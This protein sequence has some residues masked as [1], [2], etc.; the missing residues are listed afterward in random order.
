MKS[1]TITAPIDSTYI[2]KLF[3]LE[4]KIIKHI[5][6][7]HQFDG[8]HVSVELETVASQ[9][10]VC[11]HET[12]KVNNYVK[13]KITHSVLNSIPCYI[14]Y[15]AR[16]FKCPKCG[17]TFY[18]NNPFTIQ[19]M[20]ISL[21]TVYN[22]LRD[23]KSFNETF[24]SVATRYN[25][26]PT[27]VASIFDNHV[28]VPR[29]MLPEILSIDEVYAFRS[30]PLESNYVCVLL[31]FN[32]NKV[33]DI[34]PTRRYEDLKKYFAL[35]PETERKNVRVVSSDLW[36]S[37]R[38]ITK[39]CFPNAVLAAD[40]F[41]IIQDFSRCLTRV[42]IDIM[43]GFKPAPNINKSELKGKE[44]AKYIENDT[45]YYLL[46]KFHWLLNKKDPSC[47]DPNAEK[48]YNKKLGKFY[49]YYDLR[50]LVVE[51]DKQIEEV[52]YLKDELDRFYDNTTYINAAQELN[53]LIMEFSNSSIE[54][55]NKF[56][57]TLQEWKKEIINSFIRAD[58]NRHISNGPIENVNKTIK[59]IK[60]NANGYT[61]WERFR[62]RVLFV[63][64]S[65]VTFYMYPRGK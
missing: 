30:K 17:K 4:D 29:R 32:Q 63:L 36:K 10:P 19:G 35:I 14:D 11:G 15:R 38:L 46:K 44:L 57:R 9:C 53:A 16:R 3:N 37:Y 22:V 51:C 49:N 43:N 27:A 50:E 8:V 48:K 59:N 7:I 26:S 2:M 64:N 39:I 41:H 31:D 52:L 20:K 58:G 56:A 21:A 62:N 40:R 54:E 6:V 13:K 65:D 45:K 34:L 61:N 28:N 23:L 1:N 55:M 42:R 25:I 60:Y 5:N 47:F 33:V 12:S 24:K 18:E